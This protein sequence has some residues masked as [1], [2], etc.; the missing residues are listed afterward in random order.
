MKY[1]VWI[2]LI[3]SGNFVV[4][5]TLFVCLVGS[6]WRFC[7]P[8]YWLQ[9]RKI[10]STASW[11]LHAIRILLPLLVMLTACSSNIVLHPASH[12]FPIETRDMCEWPGSKCADLT[13]AEN[14]GNAIVHAVFDGRLF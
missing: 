7:F 10:Q 11:S 4:W 13:L 2:Y 8:V 5:T 12:N 3:R 6:A 9:S 14:C 1:S